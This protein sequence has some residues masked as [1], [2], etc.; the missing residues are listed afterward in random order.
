[1]TNKNVKSILI[2]FFLLILQ[3]I[4]CQISVIINTRKKYKARQP[5]IR[6]EN[7]CVGM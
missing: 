6:L 2:G 5:V 1:M 4:K 7:D 3:I